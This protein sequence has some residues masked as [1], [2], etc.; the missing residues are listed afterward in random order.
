MGSNEGDSNEQP[1][2]EVYLD[3][4][5]IDKYEVTNEQYAAYLN[6][7]LASG[8]IQAS[9]TTVTKEENELIDLDAETCQISYIEGQFIVDSGKGNY[10]VIE[11][12]W[13]GAKDFCEWAGGRLPTEAEWEKA[14][15]GTDDRK[16]PW[17]NTE[18]NS[19]HCNFNNNVG[20]TTPVGQ[21]SPT[22]NSPYGCCDMAGNVWEWCSDWYDAEYYYNTPYN[23][24]QGPSSGSYRI[25]RGGG[26]TNDSGYVL[27]CTYCNRNEPGVSSNVIGFRCVKDL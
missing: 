19:S 23:N 27:R 15:R 11:V 12:T 21:Y 8:D 18:P 4:Y 22:G 10:P 24:P 14:A 9:A 16:Y 13:Y 6:E 7:R 1:V 17:G 5:Y 26:W 20:H 25:N 2:H 3:A